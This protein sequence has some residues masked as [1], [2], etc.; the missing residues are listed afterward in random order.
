MNN[1]A[2]TELK[3]FLVTQLTPYWVQG[4]RNMLC[5]T[6]AGVLRRGGVSES[7]AKDIIAAICDAANDEEK[8]VRLKTVSYQYKL[9]LEYKAGGK[10]CAGV[11][12]FREAAREA[13]IP[14]ELVKAIVESINKVKSQ[15]SSSASQGS[16]QMGE[17][18]L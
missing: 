17:H 2:I 3:E 13:G 7:D 1:E 14:G 11:R 16:L 12:K 6:L 4:V 9:P 10:V 15:T 8:K 18:V 5:F